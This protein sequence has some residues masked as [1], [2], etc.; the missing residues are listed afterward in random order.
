MRP[1][2]GQQASPKESVSELL[3]RADIPGMGLA[4]I[5]GD[6]LKVSSFGDAAIGK[7]QVTDQTIFEAASLTKPV[8]GYLVMRLVEKK[9]LNLDD[10]LIELLPSLPL[11]KDDPRSDKVTVR[12]ALSH[13]T[14]LDGPDNRTLTFAE[15]PGTK[16]RYYPAGYR[17]VQRVIE[18]IAGTDLESLA[19]REVFEPLGM[20][21]T[22]LVFMTEFSPNLATRHNLLSEPLDRYRD[23]RA[24]ANAAASLLTTANDY[25]LFLKEMLDPKVLS[26]QSID[27]MLQSQV[28]VADTNGS[29]AWGIG[30]GL[31]PKRGTFFHYGDDGSAKCF[32]IGSR[33]KGAAMVYFTNSFNGMSIAD[34]MVQCVIPGESPSVAWLNYQ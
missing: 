14:G 20:K 26:Q 9:M 33:S 34:E 3:S 30:W 12:I 8:V 25:G 23:P 21:S 24:T 10:A 18:N 16:F 4:E 22:S 27:T 6:R 19:R 1:A 5:T 28:E 32:T 29:V 15:D 2:T 11:P 7:T 31:E 17:L 13:M